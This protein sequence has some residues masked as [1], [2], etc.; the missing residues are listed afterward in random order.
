M[1]KQQKGDRRAQRMRAINAQSEAIIASGVCP[2]C[3]KGLILGK[4][5]QNQWDCPQYGREDY[6]ADP[7]TESCRFRGVE[8]MSRYAMAN[9]AERE[10]I[11]AELKKH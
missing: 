4:F 3:G 7:S 8:L 1:A 2:E 9:D 6:R 5:F 11:Q 10:A